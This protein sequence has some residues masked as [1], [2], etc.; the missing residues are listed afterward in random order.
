MKISVGAAQI[1][2]SC[3][4]TSAAAIA[5]GKP[6]EHRGRADEPEAGSLHVS[7]PQALWRTAVYIRPALIA[8]SARALRCP[9]LRVGGTLY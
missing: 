1:G 5:S 6:S 9:D 2:G 8:S 7:P 3:D 4:L